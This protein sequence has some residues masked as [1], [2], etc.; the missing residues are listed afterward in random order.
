MPTYRFSWDAFSPET[1][2]ALARRV[3]Y[4]GASGEA[5]RAHL[6]AHA[7]RPDDDFVK[8]TKADLER[9]WLREYPGSIEIVRRLQEA[10]IGPRGGEPRNQEDAVRYL[11]K[12]RNSKRLRGLIVDA[13]RRFGDEDNKGNQTID[14]LTI[15]RFARIQPALQPLDTRKPHP[16]QMDAW[17]AL[18]AAATQTE[19]GGG[20]AGLLVMP[21]GSGKTYT[22]V[23]WLVTR[24]LAK[25]QR[26]LWIAHRD[27]L[28]AQTASAF[29]ALASLASGREI[30]RIRL[31]SGAFCSTSMIDPADDV[32]I[33][34]VASLARN[35]AQALALLQDPG[36]VVVVDE[37]HHAAARSYV[38][39]LE[40][41][42]Q[43]GNHQLIGLTATPTRTHEAERPLLA[44]LFGTKPIYQVS[45][46]ELI[47]RQV[48]AEPI[49]VRVE[50]R[51][52]ADQGITANDLAQVERF[53]ELSEAHLERIAKTNA[54]NQVIVRHYL[55]KRDLYGK[56]LVFAIN[57][58]HAAILAADFRNQGVRADYITSYR[59]D[60]VAKTDNE[61]LSDFRE[62]N[63][64]V[65]INVNIL[66]EGVDVPNAQTVFLT[67]PTRSEILV[68]QMIGRA[69]RGKAA[70]GTDKA[71]LVSFQ[72]DWETLRGWK[73]PFTLVEDIVPPTPPSDA[74][75]LSLDQP[76][77][78]EALKRLS[79]DLIRTIADEIWAR[80]NE[81]SADAFEAVPMGY[82]YAEWDS[83][84]DTVEHT[85]TVYEHQKPCFDEFIRR[86]K[87]LDP[88]SLTVERVR[89]DIFAD[90]DEPIPSNADLNALIEMLKA[91]SELV[92]SPIA[93]R[94]LVDPYALAK[95]IE[96]G[97][98]TE[99]AKRQLI[100]ERFQAP[101]AQAIYRNERAYNTA[102]EDALYELAHPDDST[103]RS[104]CVPVF[105]PL[106]NNP[107]RPG[108]H[109]DLHKLFAEMLSG[110]ARLLNKTELPGTPRLEWTKRIVKGVF[111]TA[112]WGPDSSVGE[113]RIRVNVLLD[114]PDV[115]E[116]TIRFL[117]WHEYLHLYL[118]VGHPP[119]FRELERQWPTWVQS[120][121][122][123]DTLQDRFGIEY[124]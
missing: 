89:E 88:D 47:N 85:I 10:N 76:S 20:L 32:V 4:Q 59:P 104:K 21:T 36:R 68:R 8:L 18:D 37:A 5:A 93:E 39:L 120:D 54:R 28:L 119:K 1:V 56:T 52:I 124:W 100:N 98:L 71:Y 17:K 107:L 112:S 97:D 35:P 40:P 115:S 57:V 62:G 49:P 65:L 15:K 30:L 12:C 118:K 27:E 33:A 82:Y 94:A 43:Q 19:K 106:P 117:L 101:L 13:M 14:P 23:R 22:T 67:R 83:E 46:Q 95:A 44:R 75:A 2:H 61:L 84:E 26:V 24:V 87:P 79:W 72:D 69:L 53:K 105:E 111:A 113:G 80:G 6:S 9:T 86:G 63:L 58:E 91:G 25:G 96:S 109:H 73:D 11:E 108:P 55:D 123:M 70:G 42:K 81:Y 38:N 34:S 110:G 50:T 60:E 45:I 77:Q 31:V 103:R 99:R 41:F 122:E 90:C 66:T 116:E 92:F 16:H 114:S 7:L 51:L 121:T 78:Q 3:G 48:L 64:E 29:Y 74:T 102:V